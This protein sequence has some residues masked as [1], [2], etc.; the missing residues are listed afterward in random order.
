MIVMFAGDNELGAYSDLYWSRKNKSPVVLKEC[1]K[2]AVLYLR[3]SNGYDDSDFIAMIWNGEK[4][5]EV[6]YASTRG[7]TY[8]C[9]ASVDASPELMDQYRKY[10]KDESKK[11][12]DCLDYR[13][14]RELK[15]GRDVKVVNVKR[16]KLL[17]Y[18]GREG[19]VFWVGFGNYGQSAGVEFSDTGEKVF[20]QAE[21][22]EVVVKEVA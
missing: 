12:Q 1:Y 21:K 10:L 19:R 17:P 2:G 22:L 15:K 6:C 4:F 11:V 7:W 9:S 5:F 3:E 20:F 8:P 13:E 14:A 18:M 16:G